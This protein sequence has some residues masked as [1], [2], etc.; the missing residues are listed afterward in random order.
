M[1]YR[2]PG[3]V[4]LIGEH[5]DYNLGFVLP[6][7]IEL[8]CRVTARPDGERLHVRS[9]NV[10]DER[11][12]AIQDVPA[13]AP[14]GD[15]SDYVAG[16][17]REIVRAGYPLEPVSL[18]IESDVPLGSGLSSSASL[19]VSVALAL[20]GPREV[21]RMEVARICHRAEN[22]FAGLPCGIMDHFTS[23]FGRSGHAL[24][25]DCRDLS[26]RA[27]PIPA[28]MTVLA[29]NTMV[30]HELGSTAYA[31]RVAECR[32][33]C[34]AA[35]VA[36]LRDLTPERLRAAGPGLL[37]E[38]PYRRA[39]HVVHE[40]QRVLDF[41]AAAERGDP[42]RMRELMRES[43]ESLRSDYEVS[44]DELDFLVDTACEIPGVV[45]A[46][47]TGGGFG[48]CTVNLVDPAVETEFRARIGEAYRNRFG[49]AP[50][51]YACQPSCGAGKIGFE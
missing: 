4:N 45:G 2:A 14:A 25:L 5:T 39:R 15:W 38:V 41:V 17:A 6:V 10:D 7:A 30:R 50:E 35:G 32:S 40:N 23:L 48:G 1:T 22:D 12:W 18:D 31:T 19:E 16:V 47:M 42:A 33:A 49:L 24:L 29:V 11:V 36:S 37:G 26:W 20:L 3:R 34:A 43:H 28:G 21:D 9:R 13:L 8:A 46:R 27:I 51:I 44:C